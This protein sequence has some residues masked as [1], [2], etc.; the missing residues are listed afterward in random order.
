MAS[1]SSLHAAQDGDHAGVAQGVVESLGLEL[2]GFSVVRLSGGGGSGD[3][4]GVARQH[5][6]ARLGG[7]SA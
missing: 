7:A 2:H 5:P 1:A 6:Q 4:S 3:Q